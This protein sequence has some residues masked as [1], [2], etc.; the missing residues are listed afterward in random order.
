MLKRHLVPSHYFLY[1][2]RYMH[3]FILFLYNPCLLVDTWE[4]FAP[5]ST[6]FY[7]LLY[8]LGS[9]AA[10]QKSESQTKISRPGRKGIH[11]T[12]FTFSTHFFLTLSHTHAFRDIYVCKY[13]L[14]TY[15]TTC[16]ILKLNISSFLGSFYLLSIFIKSFIFNVEH[17]KNPP[18]P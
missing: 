8:V 9:A 11:K 18:L 1:F 17:F 15:T 5:R 4:L 6:Y 12:L 16:S 3:T 2:Y 10:C 7:L 13:A 14:H